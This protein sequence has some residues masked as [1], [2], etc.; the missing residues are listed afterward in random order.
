MKA[1]LPENQNLQIQNILT[2]H[3]VYVPDITLSMFFFN[4]L[5]FSEN[6]QYI[7]IVEEEEVGNVL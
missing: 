3:K 5:R 1:N 6:K 7:S 2:L 4:F